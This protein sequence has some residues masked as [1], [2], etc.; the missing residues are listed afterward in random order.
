MTT[1]A[2]ETVE[3]V[4][5]EILPTS[6]RELMIRPETDNWMAVYPGDARNLAEDLCDTEFVP[7]GLRGKPHAALAV[8]LFGR[9]V[10][11][12]PIAAMQGL[13]AVDG[14]VGLYSETMRAM[15]LAAGHEY[16]ITTCDSSRCVIEGRRAGA[17]EWQSF[18]FT[19]QEARDAGLGNKDNWKKYAPD[20]LLAR[21]TARMCRAIFPDAI[22]GFSA[23]EELQDQA[24]P[25][26]TVTQADPAAETPA[27]TTTVS[28]KRRT[29]DRP[30]APEPSRAS[31]DLEPQK[32]PPAAQDRA[33]DA[34]SSD[35]DVEPAAH[36]AKVAEPVE[37][38]PDSPATDGQTKAIVM[39]L[40]GRLKVDDREERLYWTAAAAGLDPASIT[41]T[42]DLTQAQ[43]ARAV[44]QLGKAKDL[45][46]L[47][48]L[49]EVGEQA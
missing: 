37:V 1:T 8:I 49:V 6:S 36:P 38:D 15:V 20:M 30:S 44:Q 45:A 27:K 35:R 23:A 41:S 11:M 9:E 5:G 10:G 34:D 28:R 18:T 16:R 2:T 3:V 46:A 24:S 48:R 31:I 22:R 12:S 47:E 13:Y 21:A 32:T 17:E 29:P 39:H 4:T 26:V 7:K 33:Q 14:R 42:K 40:Q 19:M 25:A 43:A